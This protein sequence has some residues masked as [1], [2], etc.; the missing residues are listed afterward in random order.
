MFLKFLDDRL[1]SLLEIA[2]I[3]GSGQHDPHVQRIDDRVPQ[4]P[5]SVALDDLPCHSLDDRRLSD[6]GVADEER[7]VLVSSDQHLEAAQQL[8]LAPDQGIDLALLGPFVEI[9]AELGQGGVGALLGRAA[10]L[11]FLPFIGS[12]DGRRILVAGILGNAVR[13]EIDR[14]EAGHSVRPEKMNGGALPFTEDRHENVGAGD[15]ARPAG[16]THMLGRALK[17]ALK[18]GRRNGRLARGF[19]G[20]G[21]GTLLNVLLEVHPEPFEVDAA[22]EEDL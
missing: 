7:I 12:N 19:G 11:A 10:F 17:N 15:L 16:R 8:A 9:H 20:S 4:R 13:N 3:A 1:E 5:G 2:P 22:G 6:P 14:V 21:F 18:T